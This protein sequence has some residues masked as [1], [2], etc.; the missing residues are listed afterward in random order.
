MIELVKV[1]NLLLNAA[2]FVEKRRRE[3]HLPVKQADEFTENLKILNQEKDGCILFTWDDVSDKTNGDI[4]THIGM[5]DPAK[6]SYQLL[7]TYTQRVK[8]VSCSVNEGRSLIAFSVVT[9]DTSASGQKHGKETYSAYLAEIRAANSRVFSLNLERPHFLKIQFLYLGQPSAKECHM[10]V[11]LH[12]ESIGLYRIP[13]GRVGDRG[14]VMSKQPETK[15]IVK[16]FVWCQWDCQHQQLY[17]I[18]YRHPGARDQNKDHHVPMMSAIQFYQSAQYENI[19]DVLISFPFPH[20]KTSMRSFYNSSILDNGISDQFLNLAVLTQNNGTLCICCQQM[21]T[22]YNRERSVSRMRSRTSPVFDRSRTSPAFDRSRTSPGL[23]KTRTSPSVE[24]PKSLSEQSDSSSI[25]MSRTSPD[26]NNQNNQA[27]LT[28]SGNFNLSSVSESDDEVTEINYYI[29][30]VH[31]AKVLHGCVSGVPFSRRHRLHFSWHGDYLMVLLPGYFIHMLNVSIEFEPCHHI[32]L[33]DKIVN[34]Q[35][36]I[37]NEDDSTGTLPKSIVVT[38]T[39]VIP[40]LSPLAKD[41]FHLSTSCLYDILRETPTVGCLFDYRTGLIWKVEINK[42][43]LV[44]MF[45]ACY[46]PTTRSALLHFVLLRMR[47]FYLVKRLFEM[48]SNDIPSREVPVLMSEF[49]TGTTYSNMRRQTDREILKQFPFSMAETFRG[50]IEK[51][52]DGERL[53]RLSY[54]TLQSINIITKTAK[55]RQK[56]PGG[57]DEDLWDTLRRHLRLKQIENGNR[58]SQKVVQKAFMKKKRD[59]EMGQTET[60]AKSSDDHIGFLT[61]FHSNLGRSESPAPVSSL[62]SGSAQVRPDTVLGL[63][64]PFLQGNTISTDSEKLITL[65]KE[66]LAQ[67]LGKYLR[68]DAKTKAQNV[69]K[70]YVSC[71][72]QQSRQLCHLLWNLRGPLLPYT[73]LDYLPHLT[74]PTSEDEY[75]LFQMFERYQRVCNEMAFPLPGGFASYFAALGFRNLTKHLFLQYVDYGVIQLTGEFLARVLADIKDTEEGVT[76]KHQLISRLPKSFMEECYRQWNHPTCQ[77]YL[78]CK[79]VASRLTESHLQGNKETF[80]MLDQDL[81]RRNRAESDASRIDVVSFPPLTSF[82]HML[83]KIDADTKKKNQGNLTTRQSPLDSHFLQEVALYHTRT[84][85]NY[86]MSTTNF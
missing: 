23:D 43:S 67:H 5:Y 66:L 29:S 60:L 77:H 21:D 61:S 9:K 13:L 69:A 76:T 83:E 64:P 72:V 51:T 36:T 37:T 57:A 39:D 28:S 70:E 17:Y 65:T 84:K 78:A 20:V 27:C 44:N 81:F 52:E 63:A 6:Q 47:D 22:P 62:F 42:D 32:L 7:Y 74:D 53:A 15:P 79:Q 49:L 48:L 25:G 26:D 45:S 40:V 14:V 71:Q 3:L 12:K 46:M 75:E 2:K 38:S 24:R 31:H 80:G 10:I 85:T 16:K 35:S 68:K 73:D 54:S 59:I 33:H 18:H 41:T 1:Q 11:M 50:Q 56:K 8:V 4:V 19:F 86:D 82:L 30:M 58:F 34:L 55:E